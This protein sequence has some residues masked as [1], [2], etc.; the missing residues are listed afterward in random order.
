MP[1]EAFLRAV[2]AL[3][4]IHIDLKH[5]DDAAH[6]RG[7]GAGLGRIL[8]NIRL[9]LNSG[10]PTILRIPV[11]PGYNDSEEDARGFAKLLAELGAREAHLLPFH[12]MGQA[13][14]EALGLA[15]AYEGVPNMQKTA[16]AP[17][18]EIFRAGGFAVQLGG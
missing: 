3:D 16:L 1:E 6:R 9:A 13:K 18:A 11:I 5:Y 15:Y 4:L 14:W 12:Q 2:R 17:L 8:E 10:V 7:T